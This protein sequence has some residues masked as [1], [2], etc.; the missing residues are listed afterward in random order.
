MGVGSDDDDDEVIGQ[1]T[2][3]PRW[4][5][6]APPNRDVMCVIGSDCGASLLELLSVSIIEARNDR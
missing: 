6:S 4:A 3:L 5:A 2:T 1:L